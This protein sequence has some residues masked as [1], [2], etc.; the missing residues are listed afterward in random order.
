MVM[1]GLSPL[2]L[3]LFAT[4]TF[5]DPRSGLDLTHY[6]TFLALLGGAV[7]LFGACVLTV[8]DINAATEIVDEVP[9]ENVDET[10]ALLSGPRKRNEEGHVIAIKE[11]DEGTLVDLAKDPYFWV[12]FVFMSLTVGCVRLSLCCQGICTDE[13]HVDRDGAVEY[14]VNNTFLTPRLFYSLR[15][16]I[17]SYHCYP[18]TP[19]IAREYSFPIALRDTRGY[20]V[21]CRSIS[22]QRGLLFHQETA[23]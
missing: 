5:T 13:K 4:N 21:S 1:Y 3:S 14:R 7:N 19:T 6:L 8:P 11:P 10:T 20:P 15:D 9:E 12:L 2:F 18:S 16:P 23:L 22:P 17:R